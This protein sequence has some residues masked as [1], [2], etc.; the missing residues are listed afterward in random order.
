MPAAAERIH[1][2]LIA[3]PPG[4]GD[5]E[6]V[7]PDLPELWDDTGELDLSD[8][9]HP[10]SGLAGAGYGGPVPAPLTSEPP[11]GAGTPLTSEPPLNAQPPLTS[12][13]TVAGGYAEP[14][15]GPEPDGI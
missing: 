8:L 4:R 13:A 6:P 5:G 2:A 11:I 3:S 9:S 14:P 1:P 7:K 10:D 12:E 15:V